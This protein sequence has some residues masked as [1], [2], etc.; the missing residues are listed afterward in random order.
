MTTEGYILQ[1]FQT[2]IFY[3]YANRLARV[4][5]CFMFNV[6]LTYVMCVSCTTTRGVA[7]FMQLKHMCSNLNIFKFIQFIQ[8]FSVMPQLA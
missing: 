7:K 8:H 1:V 6:H 2:Y 5:N 4:Q 3:F